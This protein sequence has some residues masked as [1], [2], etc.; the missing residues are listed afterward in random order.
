[1][2]NNS[3]NVVKFNLQ[4]STYSTWGTYGTQAGQFDG[5]SDVKLDSKGNVYVVDTGNN[6]VE[7]FTGNGAY[8]NQF[9]QG[10]NASQNLNSPNSMA[11]DSN[12]TAYIADSGNSRVVKYALN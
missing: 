7:I 5:P 3:D 6:R 2:N 9:G 4:T 1:V 11:I 10:S 12:G 8:L